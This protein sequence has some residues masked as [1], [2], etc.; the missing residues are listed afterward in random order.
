M[1]A[2]LKRATF[3]PFVIYRLALGGVLLWLVYR[4]AIQGWIGPLVTGS[5]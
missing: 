3:L 1:M 5:G 4:E 2:W